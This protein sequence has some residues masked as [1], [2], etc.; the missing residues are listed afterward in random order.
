MSR[1]EGFCGNSSCGPKVR[2]H[3]SWVDLSRQL[4]IEHLVL[5]LPTSAR[6]PAIAVGLPPELSLAQKAT[7]DLLVR[8]RVS[9]PA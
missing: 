3:D 4:A 5:H 7:Y 2:A 9:P 6:E 1:S 8:Q